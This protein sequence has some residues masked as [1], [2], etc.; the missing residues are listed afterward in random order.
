MRGRLRYA[1]TFDARVTRIEPPVVLEGTATGELEG[2]GVWTLREVEG[3]TEARY[4]WNIRTTRTF[5]NLAAPLPFVRRI[6][7]LN[8][9]A[10]MGSGLRGISGLLGCRGVRVRGT[11]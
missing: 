6:F 9:D 3:W 2:T 5:M 11:D 4:D 10:V 7:E 1:L 8:H